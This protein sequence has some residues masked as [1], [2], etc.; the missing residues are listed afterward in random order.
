MIAEPK[1]AQCCC[2]NA[3]ATLIVLL[4]LDIFVGATYVIFGIFIGSTFVLSFGMSS[5]AFPSFFLYGAVKRQPCILMTG[6]VLN[7]IGAVFVGI[8]C[9]LAIIMGSVFATFLTDF[10]NTN[11]SLGRGSG[12]GLSMSSQQQQEKIEEIN[13]LLAG[14]LITGVI[15]FMIVILAIYIMICYLYF[16]VYQEAKRFQ[17]NQVM[18]QPVSVVMQSSSYSNY[19]SYPYPIIQLPLQPTQLIIHPTEQAASNGQR[20]AMD[21]EDIIHLFIMFPDLLFAIIAHVFAWTAYFVAC[22]VPSEIFDLI[23]DKYGVDWDIARFEKVDGMVQLNDP[24]NLYTARRLSKRRKEGEQMLSGKNLKSRKLVKTHDKDPK[25]MGGSVRTAK[26]DESG[27]H[28]A[29][30]LARG[31]DRFQKPLEGAAAQKGDPNYQTLHVA[32][33]D[34]FGAD[35]KKKKKEFVMPKEVTKA[36]HNDPQY[37]TLNN[38]KDDVFKDEETGKKKRLYLVSHAARFSL[39]LSDSAHNS[40]TIFASS[41]CLFLIYIIGVVCMQ[42]IGLSGLLQS[43]GAIRAN[44]SS[45]K[46]SHSRSTSLSATCNAVYQQ[47]V[48]Q[49]GTTAM[50]QSLAD[51]QIC[52]VRRRKTV[53]L[54]VG[55]LT[56]SIAPSTAAMYIQQ[57]GF[58]SKRTSASLNRTNFSQ[59]IDNQYGSDG[60]G[61]FN[62]S[63]SKPKEDAH[64]ERWKE[65][66]TQV[67]K[68]PDSEYKSFTE[69]F[70]KGLLTGRREEDPNNTPEAKK[71]KRWGTIVLVA[72][73]SLMLYLLFSGERQIGSLIFHHPTEV[74]PEEVHVTFEDVRG[75]DEAKQEVEEIVSYLRDPEK[76]SRLGGRLPKGVLLVPFFHTSGSEFDEV[77]VGQGARRV[78]DLFD[79]AKARSPCIIF[80]DEIDSVGS[81]RVSNSFHPYANQTINQLLSEMD[82]FHR[83]EGIIV[84]AATNRA[85]DLDKALLRPGRFDVRVQVPKPDLAGRKDIFEFYLGKIVHAASVDPFILAKAGDSF[86]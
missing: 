49:I 25:S 55:N 32:K 34:P 42:P 57:R 4:C 50:R 68:I 74:N 10:A 7:T 79:K 26:Y 51:K 37:E 59:K 16:I 83:N 77:L 71:R 33:D 5:M 86:Y 61:L 82:G 19:P 58:R 69:G 85:E 54:V 70:I 14:P 76:Y 44:S 40:R 9:L 20:A 8:C 27:E 22:S 24:Q 18:I 30:E 73:I 52:L 66:E 64:T 72:S 60:W 38:I 43:Y 39:F 28:T 65:F 41:A 17:N 81:K 31:Q 35:K 56:L 2:C 3:R 29:A 63:S 46:V 11:T 6:F 84:I 13:T 53:D 12:Q 1:V 75:M 78:R 48:R 67:K 62:D 80:I 21:I 45:H 47:I 15:I 23:G 36:K